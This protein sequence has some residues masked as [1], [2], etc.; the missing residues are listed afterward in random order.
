MAGIFDIE[1]NERDS[2]EDSDSDDG[3]D[4]EEV[5]NIYFTLNLNLNKTNVCM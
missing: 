5:S 3:I 4:V 1:I 2:S